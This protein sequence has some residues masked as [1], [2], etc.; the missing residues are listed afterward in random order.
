MKTKLVVSTLIFVVMCVLVACGNGSGNVAENEI[1]SQNEINQTDS[2]KSLQTEKIEPPSVTESTEKNI[3]D[4]EDAAS[5][6][7]GMQYEL[8]GYAERR[9]ERSK[10]WTQEDF[11]VYWHLERNAMKT[12][13]PIAKEMSEKG[14]ENIECY[15]GFNE[16]Y[17]NGAIYYVNEEEELAPVVYVLEAE[18][19]HVY[20]I[21]P[22]IFTEEYPEGKVTRVIYTGG[23][24]WSPGKGRELEIVDAYDVDLWSAMYSY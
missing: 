12:V 11:G 15:Q 9:R 14:W 23:R 21:V 10:D 7:D 1:I 8:Y 17:P 13:A 22:I 24:D 2:S 19:N 20:L 6:I 3:L 4:V 18:V 16:N 5:F